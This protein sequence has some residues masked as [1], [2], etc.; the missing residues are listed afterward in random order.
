MSEMCVGA[1]ARAA[2]ERGFEVVMPH[3]GHATYTIKAAPDISGEVPA[4]MVARV[5]EWALGDEIE[6]VPRTT[7]VNFTNPARE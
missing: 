2:L 4:E 3:D 7:D 1:T 6:I 5:A